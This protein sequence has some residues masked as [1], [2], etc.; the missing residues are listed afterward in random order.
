MANNSAE[1]K[2]ATRTT[3]K[4]ADHRSSR[5]KVPEH[6]SFI[7]VR[8]DVRKETAKLRE[9]RE[10]ESEHRIFYVSRPAEADAADQWIVDSGA[11][12][13]V[14]GNREFFSEIHDTETMV[15]VADR[16]AVKADGE[17]T[18]WLRCELPTGGTR[19]VEVR[20]VLYV[21]SFGQGLLSVGRITDGGLDVKFTGQE[22]LVFLENGD[23]A[24]SAARQ[25]PELY[26]LKGVTRPR[27]A[28][29][30]VA[31]AAAPMDIWHR[32]LGHRDPAAILRLTREGLADGV[33]IT[34]GGDN[35]ADCECCA[36]GKLAARPFPESESRAAQP[37]DLV[38]TRVRT[39]AGGDPERKSLRA[40][41]YG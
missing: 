11:T 36:M 24:F 6:V 10:A 33:K 19:D 5:A 31:I 4:K 12:C 8:E 2:V 39:N 16:H 9:P 17:G 37:L 18:G 15:K 28:T 13:N 22:C 41:L 25:G 1:A 3:T 38:H 26:W 32:R 29:A 21:P 35:C 34:P 20:N 14:T 23:I 7:A 40:H 27:T 30:A